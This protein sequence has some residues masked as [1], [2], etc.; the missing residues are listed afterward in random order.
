[1]SVCFGMM[2]LC[3]VGSRL[4]W[5]KMLMFGMNWGMMVWWRMIECV[6]DCV[7]WLW[8]CWSWC[9]YWIY[10]CLMW[11]SGRWIFFMMLMWFIGEFILGY[12]S[13]DECY[14]CWEFLFISSVLWCFW[15]VWSCIVCWFLEDEVVFLLW[16]Y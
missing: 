9:M 14:Y 2:M 6:D 10:V 3:V 13:D 5:S 8:G 16:L 4:W 1:M 15:W 7:E 12:L 11:N